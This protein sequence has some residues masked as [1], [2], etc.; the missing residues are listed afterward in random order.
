MPRTSRRRRLVMPAASAALA[1]G[2][3]LLPSGA[4]ATSAT[5]HTDPLTATAAQDA[6]AGTTPAENWKEIT[7]SPTGIK[8]KLPGKAK[9][10][11][12]TKRVYG[13]VVHSRV[14]TVESDD[15][16]AGLTVRDMG[17]IRQPLTYDLQGFLNNWNAVPGQTV[18][19]TSTSSRTTT[20]DGHPALDV[21]L[22]SKGGMPA[23]GATCFI[24]DG[25]HL[26]QVLTL[27][28][29]SNER[30]TKQIHQQILA[31]IRIP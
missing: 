24:A 17:S 6:S 14:Y 31:S 29:A 27:G 5:P 30:T 9:A 11:K 18:K 13:K 12:A 25:T 22:T 10:E 21:R 20:V 8:A 19:L 16:L 7:D 15:G 26:V 28:P 3:A 4:F 23:A 2:C 1:A